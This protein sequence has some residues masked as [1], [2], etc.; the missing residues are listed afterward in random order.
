[1]GEEA[2]AGWLWVKGA[3]AAANIGAGC[4][5]SAGAGGEE[6]ANMGCEF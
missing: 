1:M 2:A 5:G 6:A 3:K 4:W